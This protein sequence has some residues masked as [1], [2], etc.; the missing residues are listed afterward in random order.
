[1]LKHNVWTKQEGSK[2]WLEKT[3]W[4]GAS[5]VVQFDRLSSDKLKGNSDDRDGNNTQHEREEK[6]INVGSLSHD[7]APPQIGAR[8]SITRRIQVRNFRAF[9]VQ[10][11]LSTKWLSLVSPHQEISGS[12]ETEVWSKHKTRSAGLAERLGGEHLRRRYTKVGPTI[13]R[14]L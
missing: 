13:R 1:M 4:R 9:Y 2:S 11:R 5:S 10:Y 14:V 6:G 7:Y 3:A 8:K 12:L